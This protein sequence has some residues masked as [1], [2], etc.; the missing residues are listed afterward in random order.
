[1]LRELHKR[2][3]NGLTVTLYADFSNPYNVVVSCRVVDLNTGSDFV[4]ADIPHDKVLDVFYHPLAS[5][6][7]LLETGA[8]V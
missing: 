8:L 6:K 3:N 4:I 1:M 5:G 2:E 7:H